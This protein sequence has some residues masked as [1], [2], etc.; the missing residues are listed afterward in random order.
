MQP[1][2]A[3]STLPEEM[4]AEALDKQW[5]ASAD[6][7]AQPIPWLLPDRIPCNGLTLVEG[8]MRSGKSLFLTALAAAVT[9]G[10]AF[11][12]R[13]K[14]RP[15]GVLWLAGEEDI[16]TDVRPRLAAAG[17][18]LE[19]VHH[20]AADEHGLPRPVKIPGSLTELARAIDFYNVN[21]VVLDPLSS[22]I[23]TDVDLHSETSCRAVLDPLHHL[24]ASRRCA[25]IGT[26]HLRKSIGGLRIHQGLGSVAIGS[27]ARAII[28]IDYPDEADTRR[29]I[30]TVKV[31]RCSPPSPCEF[32]I[33]TRSGEPVVDGLR[34]LDARTD[35]QAD[36]ESD[37]VDRDVARDAELLLREA[38]AAD[39]VRTTA[40]L[41]EAVSASISERTLRT[42]KVRLGMQR[43]RRSEAGEQ[44][45][46]WGPPEGGWK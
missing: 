4:Q 20:Q 44:F 22:Y 38:C 43:R 36:Q 45:W 17:A 9:K 10:R 16:A 2:I 14:T 29:I 46:E 27:L 21:L 3:R 7:A 11:L 8:H 41:R 15:A 30:R 42:V 5:I 26:R 32:R 31:S 13:K 12:G 28:H 6:V 33:I 25:I 24:A 23:S 34:E 40:L 1:R 35:D 39:W 18:S 19:R 37:P